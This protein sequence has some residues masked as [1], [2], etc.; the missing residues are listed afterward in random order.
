MMSLTYHLPNSRGSFIESTRRMSCRGH[1]Q[2]YFYYFRHIVIPHWLSSFGK[3]ALQT[4][5]ICLV[6][7]QGGVRCEPSLILSI[8][9]AESVRN[10]LGCCDGELLCLMRSIKVGH[11]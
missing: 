2:K 1:L 6:C 3:A 8:N 4:R 9:I 11:W 5:I 7:F 10:G